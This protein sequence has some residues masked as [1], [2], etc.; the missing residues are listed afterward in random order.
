MA[1]PGRSRPEHRH[2]RGMPSRRVLALTALAAV[3]GAVIVAVV[4]RTGDGGGGGPGQGT[5]EA[6]RST[7]PVPHDGDAADDPAIWVDPSDPA[8]SRVLGTD[9]EG[10]L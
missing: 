2:A 5:V 7:D 8:R 6:S 10:G 9:K 3:V 4:L 1:H